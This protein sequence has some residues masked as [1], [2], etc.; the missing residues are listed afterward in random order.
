MALSSLSR[1][2]LSPGLTTDGKVIAVRKNAD[3]VTVSRHV[4]AP[5]ETIEVLAHRLYGDPS[6]WW[7]I[8]DVNPQVSF[9][10]DISPG[11]EIRLPR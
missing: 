9:P 8:A 3:A 10:L 2:E 1:Y 11:M 5:G 7:R 4:V 6:Q